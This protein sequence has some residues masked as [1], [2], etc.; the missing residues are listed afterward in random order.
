MTRLFVMT[1][2][3]L[4][5]TS[6]LAQTQSSPASA[7]TDPQIAMIV[8]TADNVDIAAGK[9]AAKKSSNPKVKEFAES[10]VRD[11]TSVNK[12]AT[13]LAKKLNLTPEQSPTSQSL[14][15]DGEKTLTKLR[16]LKGAEFDK[17]Y[18]DNEV[19]YHEAVIKALDDTLVPN[20]KNAEL[21]ALLETGKPIFTSHLDHAKELQSSLK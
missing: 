7:P 21:K 10:M 18:I 13:D 16:G 20:A 14:K 3:G 12:Q 19:A 11:H 17:A 8:V 15:S 6:V 2:A 5:A 1:L 9:V 4:F